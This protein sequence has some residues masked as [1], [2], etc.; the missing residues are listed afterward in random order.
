MNAAVLKKPIIVGTNENLSARFE[1]TASGVASDLTGYTAS[2]GMRA[3]GTTGAADLGATAE[4]GEVVVL[5]PNAVV[6]DIVPD[7]VDDLDPGIYDF[8]V[9][10]TAPGGKR[11]TRLRG[12]IQ[13][14]LGIAP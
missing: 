6:I 8:E 4:D 2:F 14:K 7:R 1:F 11:T 10:L 5:A 9:V 13:L 3:A 12:T